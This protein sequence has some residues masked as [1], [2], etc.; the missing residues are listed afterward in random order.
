MISLVLHAMMIFYWL[1]NVLDIILGDSGPNL[2]Y[3]ILTRR[4]PIWVWHAGC[5]LILWFQLWSSFQRL[6]GALSVC[7]VY[8]MPLEL[9]LV[10]ADATW[11]IQR[12]LTKTGYLVPLDACKKECFLGLELVVES[13]FLYLLDTWCSGWDRRVTGWEGKSVS[14]SCLLT[15]GL[16]I[17][18]LCCFCWFYLVLSE[19]LTFDLQ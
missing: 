8:L 10:P 1:L 15:E 4:H 7:L 5:G 12:N 18:P 9:L 16:P 19:V 11:G 3:F 6:H 17:N 13:T 2:N 14:S